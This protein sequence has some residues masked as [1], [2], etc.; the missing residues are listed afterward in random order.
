LGDARVSAQRLPENSPRVLDDAG[1][2]TARNVDLSGESFA[3]APV[4]PEFSETSNYPEPLFA[5]MASLLMVYHLRVTVCNEGGNSI[6]R[7][8]RWST[9]KSNAHH[10]LVQ[11]DPPLAAAQLI[12][13]RIDTCLVEHVQAQIATS[14]RRAEGL[15]LLAL[16]QA[17]VPEVVRRPALR[18]G[19]KP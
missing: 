13:A 10:G 15:L 2:K 3:A 8:R 18:S 4:I 16:W 11:T 14:R 17:V 1:G 9:T 5:R 12:D 19:R 7:G 6:S